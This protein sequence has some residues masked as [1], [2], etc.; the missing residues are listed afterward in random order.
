MFLFQKL[1]RY[2]GPSEEIP[3]KTRPRS[4]LTVVSSHSSSIFA[5]AGT[6]R[7]GL[8]AQMTDKGTTIARDQEDSS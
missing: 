4:G 8:E 2:V 5:C 1:E 3:P 7:T 6:G